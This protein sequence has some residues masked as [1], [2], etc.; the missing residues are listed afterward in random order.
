LTTQPS[1]RGKHSGALRIWHW[2]SFICIA[3]SLITVLLA[4]TLFKAKNNVTLVQEN[5]EKNK[6]IVNA[7]QAKSVAHEF[8]DLIW[9]WHIYIGYVLAALLGFR[10]LFE[11][12]QPKAQKV[13]PILKNSFKALKMPGTDKSAEKHFLFVKLL[14][15]FFYFSLAVQACT[16]IFMAYSDDMPDLKS[17][18]NLASDIHSVN[19]WVIISYIVIHLGG[20]ILAELGSK[21]KGVVSDM[22]NGGE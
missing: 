12:F 21:N 14:Y 1:F 22:I 8:S 7:D 5:L 18:R 16:G 2:S 15:L 6:I 11:F 20:V 13:I 9:H 19:M 17:W 3:G 10:I 4:K